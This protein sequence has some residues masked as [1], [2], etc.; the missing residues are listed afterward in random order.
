MNGV[1]TRVSKREFK[2]QRQQTGG[3][4]FTHP[5]SKRSF[6][7]RET[8]SYPQNKFS[9]YEMSS[10]GFTKISLSNPTME[11]WGDYEHHINEFETNGKAKKIYPNSFTVKLPR[12][13]DGAVSVGAC[14]FFCE[15][16]RR[17]CCPRC[18]RR[19]VSRAPP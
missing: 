15:R 14:L 3:E 8:E 17:G 1:K 19:H 9:I 18:R 2:H 16:A 13:E 7:I 12:A 4:V 11:G 10:S 5:I 6:I